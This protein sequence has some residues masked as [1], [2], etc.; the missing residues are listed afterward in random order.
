MVRSLADRTFQ[1]SQAPAAPGAEADLRLPRGGAHRDLA[2]VLP[3][4]RG[5]VRVVRGGELRLHAPEQE[6]LLRARLDLGVN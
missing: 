5:E 1:L 6:Q 2:P 3:G 4:G